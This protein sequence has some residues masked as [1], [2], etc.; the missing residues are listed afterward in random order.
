MN[1]FGI[2]PLEI[3][4]ILLLA[5]LIF[6]PK[7]LSNAS[8]TIGRSLNKL[9]KSDTW[10][11]VNQASNR[12]K[13]LPNELM[14]EAG[15]EELQKETDQQLK[16]ASKDLKAAPTQLQNPSADPVILPPQVTSGS[17]RPDKPKDPT[18]E[19]TN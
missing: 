16:Q 7:D 6:G 17:D 19:T 4:F 5:I 2:G 12:L 8:K 1:L 15:I 14:R 13:N 10:R 11:T 3:L 9:I 18:K